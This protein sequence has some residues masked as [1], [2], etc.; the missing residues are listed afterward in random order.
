MS[1]M[2]FLWWPDVFFLSNTIGGDH[3]FD[4]V[5]RLEKFHLQMEGIILKHSHMSISNGSFP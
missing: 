4:H 3:K 1:F 2:L 5:L